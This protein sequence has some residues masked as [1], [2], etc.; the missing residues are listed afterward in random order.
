MDEDRPDRI[1]ANAAYEGIGFVPA[2]MRYYATDPP[3]TREGSCRTGKPDRTPFQR[4]ATHHHST[5][6]LRLS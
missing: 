4:D 6:F 2:A 1:I 5:A 3:E